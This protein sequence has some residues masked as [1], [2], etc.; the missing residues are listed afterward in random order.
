MVILIAGVTLAVVAL[1]TSFG[2]IGT[3]LLVLGT[4]G[5]LALAF[6]PTEA[7]ALVAG[8]SRSRFE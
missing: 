4:I 6:R 2:G 5:W 7:G 1:A 3:G 8:W